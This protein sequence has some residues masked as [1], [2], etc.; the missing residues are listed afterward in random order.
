MGLMRTECR[1]GKE[2]VLEGTVDPC[3]N[4]STTHYVMTRAQLITLHQ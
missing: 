2:G 4:N 1:H 3:V